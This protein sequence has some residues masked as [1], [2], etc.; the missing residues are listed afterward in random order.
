VLARGVVAVGASGER[1]VALQDDGRVVRVPGHLS[2][3]IDQRRRFDLVAQE[4]QRVAER[5]VLTDT[6]YTGVHPL[7]VHLASISWLG[8]TIGDVR[9]GFAD[10]IVLHHHD[11]DDAGPVN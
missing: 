6:E 5:Q 9:V 4:C 3:R 2:L 8:L 1:F 7:V 11:V 10:R